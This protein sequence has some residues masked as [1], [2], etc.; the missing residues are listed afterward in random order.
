M[1]DGF[2]TAFSFAVYLFLLNACGKPDFFPFSPVLKNNVPISEF[3]FQNPTRSPYLFFVSTY[4]LGRS[5]PFG[6]QTPPTRRF[7]FSFSGHHNVSSLPPSIES[8][9]SPK[10]QRARVVNCCRCCFPP[11][12]LNALFGRCVNLLFR[13]FRH[14]PSLCRL[15][16]DYFDNQL[17]D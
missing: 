13:F 12:S 11:R 14:F 10:V 9:F 16:A 1:D 8:A 6:S 4:S 7:E 17:S 2:L 3:S 15:P 5:T